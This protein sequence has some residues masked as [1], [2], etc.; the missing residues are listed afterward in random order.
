LKTI[1]LS[2]FSAVLTSPFLLSQKPQWTNVSSPT[3][4]KLYGVAFSDPGIVVAVGDAGTIIRSIDGG[5]HWQPVSNPATDALRAVA[6]NGS[7]GIAVGISGMQLRTINGGE[8]WTELP[9]I[10]HRDMFSVAMNGF[11]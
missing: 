11:K 6:F 4:H 3:T 2:I 5:V 1:L 8:S 7:I 9:R 10:T